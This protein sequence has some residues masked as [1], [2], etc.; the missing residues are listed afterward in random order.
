VGRVVPFRK[1]PVRKPRRLNP[2]LL[3][4]LISIHSQCP[5]QA[6]GKCGLTVF[7]APLMWELHKV[8]GVADESD[9]AFRRVDPL[10]AARPL[11]PQR[12]ETMTPDEIVKSM[13]EEEIE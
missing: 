13:C 3:A 7:T 8:M 11:E 2:Q 1:V 9:K 6:Q 10:C 5:L 12:F 4:E